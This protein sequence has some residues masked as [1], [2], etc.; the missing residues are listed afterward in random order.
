[1]DERVNPNHYG[2]FSNPWA[3]VGEFYRS[4]DELI[5]KLAEA[6]H[7]GNADDVRRLNQQMANL[8]R[9]QFG[10]SVKPRGSF[11]CVGG[12]HTPQVVD[13]LNAKAA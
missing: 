10:F 4:Q 9:E 13:E 7:A 3:P 12:V 1:M 6:C 11:V 2:L 5:A 8:E